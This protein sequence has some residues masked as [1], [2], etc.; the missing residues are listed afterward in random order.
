MATLTET[1]EYAEGVYQIETTDPVIGGA[2]GI[3]NVQAKQL[4]N[5]TNFLKNLLTKVIDGTQSVAKALKLATARKISLSGAVTGNANFDGSADITINVTLAD[6]QITINSIN[7][8][9]TALANKQDS[10]ATL[11]A[12]AQV[13][14]AANKLIYATASDTFATTDL[15]AFMRTLL[16]DT[17]AAAARA[18]LGAAPTASPTFT[19]TV[20]APVFSGALSGNAATATTASNANKLI[21]M[22]WNWIGQGGQPSWLWGG[23]DASNMYV[24][25]PANFSVNYANSAGNGVSNVSGGGNGYIKFSNGVILQWGNIAPAQN[26]QVTVTYPIAFTGVARAFVMPCSNVDAYVQAMVTLLNITDL[27]SFRF[28]S[29]NVAGYSYNWFAIG[30]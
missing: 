5:R 17:D 10:D 18:T 26:A 12:L 14:T 21:G 24:Y 23:N 11:S 9:S 13:S 19:G 4:A 22:N 29:F 25:N 2:D 6:G 8:L 20:T 16:D 1:T 30:Y 15:T 7:G 28:H 3:S 27:G